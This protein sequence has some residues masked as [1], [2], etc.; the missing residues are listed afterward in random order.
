MTIG[1]A[2]LWVLLLSLAPTT[3][4]QPQSTSQPLRDQLQAKFEE[5]H[6]GGTFPG[7]TAGIVLGDGTQIALAVGVSDRTAGTRMKPTDRLL[8][9][10][11][12]KTYVS[13][14]ALQLVHE[15][16]IGLDDP[17]SK[18]LGEEPWFKRLPNA[19]RITV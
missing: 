10:S 7:G 14:V 2:P 3:A 13:A 5:L 15:K 18:Y 16:K 17:I 12:G 11:V 4:Q 1:K 8:L 19:G 9:G 6:K